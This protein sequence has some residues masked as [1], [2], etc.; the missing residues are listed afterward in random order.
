M[1]GLD[2]AQP[3]PASFV[4]AGPDSQDWEKGDPVVATLR[5]MTVRATNPPDPNGSGLWTDL[6]AL[7]RRAQRGDRDAYGRLVEQFERTVHAVCLRRLGNP[8]E[9]A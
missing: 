6:A 4:R 8:S 1:P 7:V 2:L 9:A 5:E 3:P